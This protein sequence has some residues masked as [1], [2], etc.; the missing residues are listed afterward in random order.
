MW[1]T[2]SSVKSMAASLKKFYKSMADHGY[3]DAGYYTIFAADIKE[4]V[5]IWQ[6]E[7]ADYNEE[8]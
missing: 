8:W 5:P 2:P 3:V 7:C 1:S 4:S 6:E